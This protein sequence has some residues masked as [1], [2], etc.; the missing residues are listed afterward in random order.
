MIRYESLNFACFFE[1]W[2]RNEFVIFLVGLKTIS[3]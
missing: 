2:D 1:T 3:R